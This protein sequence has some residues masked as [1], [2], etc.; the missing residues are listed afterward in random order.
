MNANEMDA[1]QKM[2]AA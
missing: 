1:L 2:N